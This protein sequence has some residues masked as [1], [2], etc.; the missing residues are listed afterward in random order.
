MLFR[1]SFLA[2]VFLGSSGLD[3]FASTETIIPPRVIISVRDQKL[4]V[5][6]QGQ[7]VAVYPVSTSKFGIGDR[8]GSMGKRKVVRRKSVER[9]RGMTSVVR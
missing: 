4:M 9:P 8:W 5:I 3:L 6:D 2:C 1:L 7:R